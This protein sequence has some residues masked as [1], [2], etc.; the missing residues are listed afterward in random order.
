MANSANAPLTV[1]YDA[2]GGTPVSSKLF[3]KS[4]VSL[5]ATQFFGAANDNILKQILTFMVATGIWSG[6][7]LAVVLAWS[8]F[9]LV[10]MIALLI[11]PEYQA[12][13]KISF[14]T[15]SYLLGVLGIAIAVLTSLIARKGSA[16]SPLPCALE[17][18]NNLLSQFENK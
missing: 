9:Y 18:S 13:L 17:Q 15:T 6:P 4:Y 1:S 10:A 5:L 12:I 14:T 7:L 11:L 3:N 8:G 16:S 2:I